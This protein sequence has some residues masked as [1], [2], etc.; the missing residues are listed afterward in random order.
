MQSFWQRVQ[1][2]LTSFLT[3]LL[4]RQIDASQDAFIKETGCSFRL[5]ETGLSSAAAVIAVVDWAL[6]YP[7]PVPP[8]VHVSNISVNYC[9]T[10]TPRM[11]VK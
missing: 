3:P 9:Q 2:Y 1:N 10:V 8:R 6:E 11:H 5:H 4:Q 7:Q